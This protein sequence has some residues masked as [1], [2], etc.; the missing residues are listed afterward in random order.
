MIT[1]LGPIRME[2][3]LTAFEDG[4]SNWGECFFARAFEDEVSLFEH[5]EQTIMEATGIKTR[6]P[7][8]FTWRSF[9]SAKETGINRKQ[10]EHLMREI[11]KQDHQD[12]ADKFLKDFITSVQFDEAV[13]VEMSC[14]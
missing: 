1:A 13:P 6:V 5:P 8:R 12:A 7:I 11:M 2:K 3:G 4:R 14:A 10:L 9:D